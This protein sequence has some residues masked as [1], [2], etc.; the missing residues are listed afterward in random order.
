MMAVTRCT[1]KWPSPQTSCAPPLMRPL[2]LWLTMLSGHHWL[3]LYISLVPILKSSTS[4]VAASQP[5]K[6]PFPAT[7]LQ[8][9][10]RLAASEL[11]MNHCAVI[12]HKIY[13]IYERRC[14]KPVCVQRHDPVSIWGI[15]NSTVIYFFFKLIENYQTNEAEG[16]PIQN[17]I[18]SC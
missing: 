3:Q 4:L 2:N 18:Y 10:R 5:S 11:W 9:D 16:I 13:H 1:H 6:C 8:L 14:F 12:I 7:D 17:A 15:N